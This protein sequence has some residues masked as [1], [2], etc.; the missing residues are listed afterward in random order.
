VTEHR[1]PV[2]LS[3]L[4]RLALVAAAAFGALIAGPNAVAATLTY[5][6][7]DLGGLGGS[8]SGWVS[9]AYDINKN[10]MVVGQAVKPGGAR[11][12]FSYTTSGGMQELTPVPGVLSAAWGVNDSGKIVGGYDSGSTRHA[13]YYDGTTVTDLGNLLG[14]LTHDWANAFKVNNLNEVSGS[15]SS[16]TTTQLGD[17]HAFY[18]DSG[19][20]HDAGGL[21]GS[22]TY[23]HGRGISDLQKMVGWCNLPSDPTQQHA[24]LYNRVSGTMADLSLI[25]PPGLSSSAESINSVP[26][27]QVAGAAGSDAAVWQGAQFFDLGSLAS[28]FPT[29]AED[30]NNLG[31]VVGTGNLSNSLTH[32]FLF[33][34][35]A[36][37][38][39]NSLIPLGSGYEILE[40]HAINDNGWIVGRAATN[41][42]E[43]AVLL[44]PNFGVPPSQTYGG[45]HGI[46]PTRVVGEPVDTASGF[47]LTSTTD[48][49][50]PGIG[51]PFAFTRSYVSGVT[52]VG[53]LGKGWTDSL[54]ASLTVLENGDV[55]LNAEDGQQL[56]YTKQADGSFVGQPG[57]RSTLTAAGGGYDLVRHDQVRYRFDG[58]G[59]LQSIKDRNSE[60]LTL[61]YD[62][63]GN[64]ATVTDSVGRQ[65]SFGYNGSLLSSVSLPDGRNV[66]YGY[67]NGLLTS[68]VDARGG[69]TTYGYDASDRLNQIIDQN[70]HT[71]VQNT[72]DAAG[73]VIEQ[74]DA[75]GNHSTFGWDPATQTATF[76]NARHKTWQDVYLNN[77]IQ[78]SIDP[79]GNVTR[80]EY[81]A[82]GNLTKVTD[83]RGNATTMTY[84]GRGN[85]LTKT[86]PAPLSY[87]EMFTYD[88]QNNL[89]TYTDARNNQ[90][91]FGYDAAGNLTSI[92]RPG[93][94][95]TQIGRDPAGTGLM[96]SFTDA[97]GKTTT[98]G[99]DSA[100]NLTQI[101]TPLGFITKMGYD[102]GGR[103]TSLIEARGNVTGGT[104]SDYTWVYTYN[105]A[106]QLLTQT[107]PLNHLTTLTYDA[108]GNL[109]TW[110]DANNHTTTYDY[111]PANHLQSV[112]AP[113]LSLTSYGYD[114]VGNLLTR[115]DAKNHTTT[116]VYDDDNRVISD[117]SQL[118]QKWTF[119]YDADGNMSQLVTA[120]GNATPTVGDGAAS[121]TYDVLNRLTQIAYTDSTPTVQFGYDPNG[122]R[123]SM[124]DGGG[125]ATFSYDAL[126]RLTGVTRGS[127]SFAYVYDPAGNLTRDTYPDNTIVD[128]TYDD[129]GRLATSVSGGLTTSYLYDVAG[130]LTKTT[131]PSG[132]GYAENRTYDRDGRLTDIRS[133]KGATTLS[134]F[135]YTLDPI[136]NP[137]SVVG[138][139]GTTTYK[140]DTL[141][142]IT[143]AC[144]QAT[145]MAGADPFIRWAYDAVGN[146]TTETRPTGVT[147][148]NYDA[149]DELTSR[150]GLGGT[151][152]YTYNAD[153]DVTAAGTRTFTYN[154]ADRMATTT[155]GNTTTTYTYD[156]D[157]NRLQASS[158]NSPSSKTNYSWDVSSA[159]PQLALERDGNNGLLRR[160]L[161]G[162][163]LY[164]M[165]TGGA[166]YYFH[167]DGL[168][169]VANLTS[170][171]GAT[172]WTYT[173]EPYGA[174][175]TETKVA[176]K[177]PTNLM[178]FN[179]Q[180]FD[181][182][183]SLYHL[184]ARQ[185][186]PAIG[187]FLRI[188]PLAASVTDPYVSAY[189][190]AADRPT[191]LTDP[192]GL[193]TIGG[194]L[195]LSG[196]IWRIHVGAKGCV[197]AS[198]SFEIGVTGTVGG[199]VGSRQGL[200]VS[201]NFGGQFSNGSC[202]KDLGGPFVTAGGTIDGNGVE[203]FYNASVRDPIYGVDV[204][205]G[206]GLG[207][208][209]YVTGR[210]YG[211]GGTYTFNHTFFGH[212]SAGTGTVGK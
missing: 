205:T 146:R 76:T 47:Y 159:L 95:V 138:T 186:D 78:R 69:T 17:D 51:V 21:S 37:Q 101:T 5:R 147:N 40:A 89:R 97:R 19:G 33:S 175:R 96:T 14:N 39:L 85:M 23:C 56:T 187:R 70:L 87:L 178:K 180:L 123:T 168:E 64:L 35:G 100:G 3:V 94:N 36:M 144:F 158:G 194:C 151:V 109:K 134:S 145:C 38:D 189:A 127:S 209:T 29:K 162:A 166:A 143:E 183:L 129:D 206:L 193:A 121:Y 142:R 161:Y 163:D 106:N 11:R 83:A 67:T 179:S 170:A 57:T 92:A 149:A 107:D 191:V 181:S 58:T 28:G 63:T 20:M 71:V 110:T 119:Q 60:G 80:Y 73:R 141:D 148:Y 207:K 2:R 135:A 79:L 52:S 198:T 103:M 208:Q 31:A 192:S 212:C 59:V 93:S 81:D 75:R 48:L 150:T 104:P 7:V 160:Y 157:G 137:T 116:Y 44:I 111:D 114:E 154:L 82:D 108:V 46:N 113:D 169:S 62:G 153:G 204:D 68:V 8:V 27:E 199:N 126:N 77:V 167:H 130:H 140:Y 176:S 54:G 86:A 55:T 174:T 18:Y 122:N 41:G 15:D 124:T 32:G 26:N 50:L 1:R 120:N 210:S 53:R 125:S 133:V 34:G 99:Y 203:G 22:Y 4:H 16:G 184:R 211:A 72:Y 74:V 173:Y 10:G 65:I 172:Q 139:G 131:L 190:Y 105:N 91:T 13:W 128:Y 188:D 6:I 185:Y 9:D 132:N 202:V 42:E 156:G 118:G 197:V 200:G 164:S 24:F 61:A 49:M 25:A 115:T 102:A 155:S 117:T 88:A 195:G 196:T 112:K 171:T 84:D 165:T 30:I 201:G 90:I 152:N 45:I 98:F 182:A 12:P 66:S 43:H 177:A 136:G